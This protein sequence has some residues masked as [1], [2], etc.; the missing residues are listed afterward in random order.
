MST[1]FGKKI[2]V[3]I[4]VGTSVKTI[5]ASTKAELVD[6]IKSVAKDMG[7]KT[8]K[9]FKDDKEVSPV[10]LGANVTTLEI[11]AFNKAALIV[12]TMFSTSTIWTV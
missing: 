10:D 1:E 12:T 3:Q 8:F 11:R 2:E 7:L 4:V 9:V 6:G 5:E